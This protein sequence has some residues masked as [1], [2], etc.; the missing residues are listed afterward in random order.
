VEEALPAHGPMT[1]TLSPINAVEERSIHAEPPQVEAP[2]TA[3][4]PTDSDIGNTQML[5]LQGGDRTAL[6]TLM[7]LYNARLFSFVVRIVNDDG[8]AEDIVQETWITL[9]EHR[10]GYQPTHKFSTWL[11]TIARRKALSELRRRAVRSVLRP[12]TVRRDDGRTEEREEPQSTFAA[13]DISTDARIAEAMVE[14]ALQQLSP[15]HREI[16]VLR[17]IEGFSNEEIAEVL[18]WQIKP[19]A[20]RKRIF[21]AREAFRRVMCD[22]GYRSP[23]S[24]S[25]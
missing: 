18:G 3:S 23:D 17:D 21:D 14:R 8:T 19:G 20:L 15:R 13:P 2:P 12:F 1:L 6:R 4:S 7:R 9:Y 24:S 25:Q 10:A 16:V 5:A 11:F 22:L